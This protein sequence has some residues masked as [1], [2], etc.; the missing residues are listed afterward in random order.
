MAYQYQF[1]NKLAQFGHCSYDLILTDDAGVM[2]ELRLMKE[3]K[4]GEDSNLEE[5]G[6]AECLKAT[7]AYQDEQTRQWVIL[8]IQEAAGLVEGYIQS[9][10][11]NLTT[12]SN[13]DAIINPVLGFYGLPAP[14]GLQPLL[15]KRLN[16]NVDTIIEA[17]KALPI[18]DNTVPA[19]NYFV[20]QVKQALGVN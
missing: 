9:T 18:T 1:I 17:F 3:F 15:A 19:T 5:I 10:D 8:Q 20:Q 4:A 2:P 7:Q 11:A 14:S 12:L 6:T 13:V 16:D